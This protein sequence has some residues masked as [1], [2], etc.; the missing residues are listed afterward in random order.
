MAKI[1][2]KVSGFVGKNRQQFLDELATL[3]KKHKLFST[4]TN[5]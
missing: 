2:V 1:D 4:V 3:C 5:E